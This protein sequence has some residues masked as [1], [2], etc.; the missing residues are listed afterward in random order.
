[1]FGVGG[2]AGQTTIRLRHAWGAVEAVRRRPDQQPVHGRRRVPEH[3]SSTGDRTACCSSATC[4]CS[5][6]RSATAARTSRIA[7]ERPG[8]SGDAGVLADR[9]ELQNVQG[10]GSRR[11]TSPAHYRLGGEV[12][13]RRSVGGVAALD[14]L[15]RHPPDR[16][17]RPERAAPRGWGISLSSNVKLGERRRAA[18]AA[19]LRRGRRELLQRRAGRRRRSRATPATR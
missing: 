13:L 15:G 6:S 9:V 4:R 10:R 16:P 2:D 18:A 8:A 1:M 11:R 7:I 5:G 12:G 3:R 19:R 14:R 17:V